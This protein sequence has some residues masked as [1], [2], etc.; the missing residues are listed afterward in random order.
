MAERIRTGRSASVTPLRTTPGI[1]AAEEVL[2][3]V[4]SRASNSKSSTV[5][6]PHL[7]RPSVSRRNQHERAALSELS[8]ER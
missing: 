3:S 4:R 2:M 1:Q 7:P 5:G 6:T 8:N